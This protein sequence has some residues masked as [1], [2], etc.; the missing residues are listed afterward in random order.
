[1]PTKKKRFTFQV[2]D[3]LADRIR[4][5]AEKENRSVANWVET[6]IEE[7]ILRREGC[8]REEPGLYAAEDDRREA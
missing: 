3:D 7:A 6:F 5:A 2:S 8:V 4:R 1:M